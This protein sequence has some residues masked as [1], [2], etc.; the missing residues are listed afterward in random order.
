MIKKRN[1]Q[2]GFTLIESIVA[3]TVF[4][5]ISVVIYSAYSFNQRAYLEGEK[6]AELAQNGRIIIERI[7]REVR[8]ATDIVTT[9]PQTDQGA[10]NP[11]EIEFQ[12]G[13]MPVFSVTN[14]AVGASTSTIIL[15]ADSSTTTDYYNNI[16]LKIIGNTGEGQIRKIIDYDGATKTATIGEE[17]SV[18]PN[19]TSVYRL[20]SEYYYIRYYVSAG[21]N[22]VHRQYRVYCFDSCASCNN[23][24]RW[25]DI[26]I[27]IPATT[28]ACVL[29]D[30]I[31]G[32][33]V[34]PGDLKFWG[35][36]VIDI[37]L[38]ISEDDREVNLSTKVFGRNF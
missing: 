15:A 33:Y 30:R 9:L 6:M 25:D 14:T 20:G 17:W 38:R 12:D 11:T 21:N 35:S 7:T 29:E 36:N 34:A 18:V 3:I 28:S 1:S 22:E 19:N 16:F 23:Y 10:A 32:E 8:Q 5:L 13:H 26:R 2:F 37:S 31:I 27:G 4:I 24:F